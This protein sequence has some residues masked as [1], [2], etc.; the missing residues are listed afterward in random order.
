MN[1]VK[2]TKREHFCQIIGEISGSNEYLVVGIDVAKDKHHAFMGTA[3]GKTLYRRLI[4]ENSRSGFVGLLEQV[5]LIR[6]Q[7]GLKKV[8]FAVEPTGNYHKPLSRYLVDSGS[9]L[10]LVTGKAVKSNREVLDGRWDKHDTKDAANIADLASRGRCQY[11]DR[12]S[13]KIIE[14]RDLLSLRRRL[15]KDEHRIRVR[16]R[17]TVLAK[18]FPELDKF[19]DTG[20]GEILSIVKWCPNPAK[21]ADMPFDRFFRMVTKR[22]RGIAQ[23]LRLMKI[24]KSAGESIGCP[25]REAAEF[26]AKLLVDKLDQ[27]RQDIGEVEKRVKEISEGFA[28]YRYLL[29]IPGFGPYVSSVVLSAIANPFRFDNASQVLKLS[30][31]D[32]CADRSGKSSDKAV[33]VISKRGSGELRYALYQAAQVASVKNRYFKAYFTGILQGRQ[34]ERGIHTKMRVKLAA[35]MLVIAWAIMKRK[36]AF[37]PGRLNIG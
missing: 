20:R 26:E 13:E 31:Y 1:D 29:T 21:I 37:D 34:K 7:N 5:E 19:F 30:G 27:V 35:K 11:Y 6:S 8:V 32:L 24:H 25:M 15:K 18:Y 3:A 22:E 14:L 16:I 17:N 33:P 28:E 9:H 2:D 10:V 4:F 23:K 36:E 12:P